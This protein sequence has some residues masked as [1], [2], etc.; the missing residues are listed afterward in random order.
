[1]K[2]QAGCN[3]KDTLTVV[4]MTTQR[5]ASTLLPVEVRCYTSVCAFAWLL[6]RVAGQTRPFSATASVVYYSRARFAALPHNEQAHAAKH[7][8]F[9]A[10]LRYPY[11]MML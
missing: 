8:T 1:M 11:Y 7:S 6:L 5:V 9:M 4:L 10:E 2:S 3:C